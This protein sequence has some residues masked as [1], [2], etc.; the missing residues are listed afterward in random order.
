MVGRPDT[1]ITMGNPATW[2]DGSCFSK[3]CR[4]TTKRKLS[5]MGQMP[6]IRDALFGRI[7]TH[8]RDDDP[9]FE[10]RPAQCQGRKQRTLLMIFL[11]HVHTP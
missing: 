4:R 10:G 9:I 8:R 6:L 3:N 5:E 1:K 11:G 2:F 7:C